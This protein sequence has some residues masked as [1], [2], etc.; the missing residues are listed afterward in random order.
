MHSLTHIHT[1]SLN[2]QIQYSIEKGL[3]KQ[4]LPTD[5]KFSRDTGTRIL[6]TDTWA[7]PVSGIMHDLIPFSPQSNSGV[8]TPHKPSQ[9]KVS[10]NDTL[11]RSQATINSFM[12]DDDDDDD[13]DYDTSSLV[14]SS[15]SLAPL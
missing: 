13:D 15:S 5:F 8:S 12:D 10:I 11:M 4:F 6:R 3:K 14:L 1:P 7:Y 9:S 2:V